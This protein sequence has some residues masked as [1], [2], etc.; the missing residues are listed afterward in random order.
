MRFIFKL[1]IILLPVVLILIPILIYIYGDKKIPIFDTHDLIAY[2]ATIISA[3]ATVFIGFIAYKQTKISNEIL[4][5]PYIPFVCLLS[6]NSEKFFE[7]KKTEQDIVINLN[8]G[9]IFINDDLSLNKACIK[10]EEGQRVFA[11]IIKNMK[12]TEILNIKCSALKTYTEFSNGKIQNIVDYP[13]LYMANDAHLKGGETVAICFSGVNVDL[14]SD[15]EDENNDVSFVMLISLLIMN[16]KGEKYK[17]NIELRTSILIPKLFFQM[18]TMDV[19]EF[20][21]ITD[22]KFSEIKKAR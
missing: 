4:A 11:F 19:L 20:P 6:C 17:E 2:S 15:D 9:I 13:T 3:S 7:S 8:S 14:F 12:N 21:Q 16:C 22:Q 10:K 18:L 1:L 5:T